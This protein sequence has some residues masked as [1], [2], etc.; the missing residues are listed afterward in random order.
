M[1]GDI[2]PMKKIGKKA[3]VVIDGGNVSLDNIIA[4]ARDGV[5]VEISKTS[6]FVKRMKLTQ[7]MLMEAMRKGVP[8]YGVTTGYGRSC[9]RRMPMNIAMKNGTNI[10]RFHGCGTGEPIGIEE[11]RAAMLCRIICLARGYSGVSVGLLKQMA[12]FLNKGITPVV[13]CEGSVGASGDLTP[14]S[15]IGAALAGER[16]VFYQGKKMSAAKAMKKAGLKPYFYLPKE[17]LSMVNGTTTM[18]GIAALNV[19]RA[20]RIL[21]AAIYATTLSVH[22]MKGNAHHYHPVMSQAKPFPGQIF[23]AQKIAHL[24]Q[25]RVSVKQLED[26]TLET[27]QDPYSLRCAPQVL[28]VLYDALNWIK[29]W[30]EI[31]ANS[32]NDNPIFDPRTGQVLMGG[33]FYGGHIAFAMDGLKAALASV[34]DMCDR[35]VML[36]VNPNLNRGLPGDLVGITETGNGLFHGFKA[37]SISSSAL[38]AEA[39]K[40]TMPA[41]SFSRS[42]ES[43]NQD[44]VSMGT[45]AARDAERICTLTERV[46]SIHL[47]AA[48]QAC[49]LRKNISV[50]PL[51]AKITQKI[52]V[53][54]APLVEDR[55]LDKDIENMCA[56]IRYS[57]FF[58][59]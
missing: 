14:M 13:P 56:A 37:M 21:G 47:M 3:T 29:K 1:K 58:R 54:S 35:Q 9:G 53:I 55:P 23:V 31:E 42:T 16:D 6:R 57:D 11:T 12:D 34:A 59:I 28:G 25:A 33:N 45:I 50:R 39:L 41:A 38:A 44:K 52:G 18:T 36:L 49:Y 51:L 22:A 2:R 8:I 19:E 27:L 43:Y 24:L 46:V 17:P 30:V 40:E 7:K 48:A 10:F 20:E 5:S 4:V 15:Y 26:N 32:S